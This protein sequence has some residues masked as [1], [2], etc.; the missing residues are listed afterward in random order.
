MR[1]LSI[2]AILV[3]AFLPACAAP[4]GGSVVSHNDVIYLSPARNGWEGLP[5]GNGTLGAQV[6]HDDGLCFQLNTPLSGVYNGALGRLRLRTR[7]ERAL[8]QSSCS[9]VLRA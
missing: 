9:P 1:S 8:R 4:D 3:S 6:W 2:T 7:P 5:L